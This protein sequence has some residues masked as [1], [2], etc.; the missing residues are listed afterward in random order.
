V[1]KSILFLGAAAFQVPP[2]EYAKGRGYRVVTCD[3]R[4]DN[5]GHALSDVTYDVS[6]TD[7]E[8][9]LEI[10]RKE[11][12]DGIL[13]YGSDVSAPTAAYVSA[14]LGLPGAS[15]RTV[16]LLTDK[17]A[18]RRLLNESGL[19]PHPCWL[20]ES[21]LDTVVPPS[22]PFPLI[23]KPTDNAGSRGISVAWRRSELEACL[24]RALR[25]SRTGRALVEP[26]LEK[27]GPQ[28][29]GDG[30]MWNGALAFFEAG[31][32]VFYD[33]ADRLAPY[34]ELF[35]SSHAPHR[36]QSLL[37]HVEKILKHAG[38][39]RGV[40]NLD[41]FFT[42]DGTPFVVEIGPRNGG[43]FI[44]Q[45][46][47][48]STGVDLVE[49]AVEAA[50]GP[51]YRPELVRTERRSAACY[52]AHSLREGLLERVEWD[53]SLGQHLVRFSPYAAKG[54]EVKEFTHAGHALANLLFAFESRDSLETTFEQIG[55]R[56]RVVLQ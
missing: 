2:I 29:C 18:F 44:P 31:D 3:N 19:Q 24:E 14:T 4:P 1:K 13:A 47:C 17:S 22:A 7:R 8:K 30:L 33:G 16:H 21:A 49:I 34:A 50:V 6:T 36:L 27:H 55:S 28:V 40:F 54:A 23:V 32:G 56:C 5:P 38:L 12:I 9:I 10:A 43:N 11:R 42:K 46:I 25:Q 45:A 39:H 20:A 41:A 26:Y 15:E 53:E 51:D 52:M 35:P 48:L 37:R